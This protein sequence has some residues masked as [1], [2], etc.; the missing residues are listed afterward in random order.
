MA[1]IAKT[2]LVFASEEDR[3]KVLSLVP[4]FQFITMV[5]DGGEN[6]PRNL[7]YPDDHPGGLRAEDL[8]PQDLTV[9]RK[10]QI[11]ENAQDYISWM[12]AHFAA[13]SVVPVLFTV[14]DYTE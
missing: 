12:T 9:T 4:W 10:W 7:G 13:I 11:K 8:L 1:V 5:G 2:V 6:H 3:N 14:E